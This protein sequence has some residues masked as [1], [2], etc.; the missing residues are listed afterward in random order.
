MCLYICIKEKG[1]ESTSW[2]T[3]HFHKHHFMWSSQQPTEDSN[4]SNLHIF[5]FLVNCIL[6][7]KAEKLRGVMISPR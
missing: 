2:F 7:V 1:G 5:Y 6:Q 3:K 4:N